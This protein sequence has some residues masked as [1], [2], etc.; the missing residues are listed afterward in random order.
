MM[1]KNKVALIAGAATGFGRTGA[2][3]FAREGAKVVIADVNDLEGKKTVEK[4]RSENCEATF[5][6][7]DVS[8][9]KEIEQ[10]VKTTVDT[11]GRIDIF[12]HNA[13]I[14]FPGHIEAIQEK[15]YDAEMAVGLRGA[16]FG[17]QAVIPLMKA[18]GGGAILYTSSMVGLRPTP[19]DPSYSLTHGLEK[20]GLIMLMRCITEPMA[21]YNIRVNCICP[22]PVPTEVWARSTAARAQKTGIDQE[23]YYKASARRVPMGRLITEEEVAAA[24]TFLVSDKAS[25]VTGAAF[26]V[27]GGF[28]AI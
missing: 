13:G 19:Y 24:A 18:A 27:D 21:R 7:A 6:H 3:M 14:F 4:M 2:R 25:S 10:M 11:Y 20:A 26:P 28:S 16:I 9:V 12:W 22:G 5:V 23:E 15:H 8:S 17:T 1:L